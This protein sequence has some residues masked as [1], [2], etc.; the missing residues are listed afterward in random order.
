MKSD[1]NHISL[2]DKYKGTFLFCLNNY[3]SLLESKKDSDGVINAF[4]QCLDCCPYSEDLH[5]YMASFYARQHK[6]CNAVPHLLQALEMNP[7]YNVA[8][9][10]LENIKSLSIKRWH[11]SMI[12]DSIRNSAY[13]K[14]INRGN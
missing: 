10:A 8:H 12:N 1:G 6:Y 5:Y 7:D 11:F 2:F 4:K 3:V 9:I 13:R 14:S